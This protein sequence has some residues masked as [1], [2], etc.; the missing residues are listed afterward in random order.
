MV[1]QCA[2]NAYFLE[3]GRVRTCWE[4]GKP[5]GS[6]RSLAQGAKLLE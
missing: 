4:G 1:I 3:L 5:R 6:D 2:R